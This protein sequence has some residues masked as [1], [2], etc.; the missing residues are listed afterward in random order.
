MVKAII[1]IAAVLLSQLTCSAHETLSASDIR[2]VEK[3]CRALFNAPS[4]IE[5]SDPIINR[6]APYVAHPPLVLPGLEVIIGDGRASALV[7][8]RAGGSVYFSY[9]DTPGSRIDT[10]EFR[11]GSRVIFSAGDDGKSP[12][13]LTK[14][15][16]ER[17][18]S[19]A[20]HFT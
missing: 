12:N 20:P 15:S 18:P 1:A 11:I 13:H 9:A 14:R 7:E 3:I 8:L 5:K 2:A 4:A 10:V 17:L 16:S 19:F 6:L